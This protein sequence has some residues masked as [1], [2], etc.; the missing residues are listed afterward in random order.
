MHMYVDVHIPFGFF[1]LTVF[2]IKSAASTCNADVLNIIFKLSLPPR[3]L[4]DSSLGGGPDS[5]WCLALRTKHAISSVCRAWR[6]VG[7]ELLYH[8]VSFRRIH[9]AYIFLD[10]LKDNPGNLGRFVRRMEVLCYIPSEEGDGPFRNVLG[11]ILERCPR[12]VAVRYAPVVEQPSMQVQFQLPLLDD[13]LS[14]VERLDCVGANN[15]SLIVPQLS[16]FSDLGSLFIDLDS[17][18]P[19]MPALPESKLE[20]SKLHT[21]HLTFPA[22]ECP[23]FSTILEHWTLP[24]LEE[25]TMLGSN[26]PIYFHTLEAFCKRFGATLTFLHFGGKKPVRD[27]DEDN[28]APDGLLDHCPHLNHLVV[29]PGFLPDAMY[30]SGIEYCDLWSYV[31]ASPN[32]GRVGVPELPLRQVQMAFPNLEG[33]RV[34]DIALLPM[35]DLPSLIWPEDKTDFEFKFPG[36]HIRKS[37]IFLVSCDLLALNEI[38]TDDDSEYSS[39]DV[40]DDNPE[41]SPSSSDD[42]D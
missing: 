19:D 4:L 21:L 39:G 20:L 16:R 29:S 41:D 17:V 13:V 2:Q 9:Q 25:L 34:L 1:V 42:S 12:L 10:I 33:I 18:A 35:L 32:H 6:N 26:H 30:H 22:K 24:N 40:Q 14:R 23:L 3:Y 36:I 38:M 37:D 5:P 31:F 7:I 28:H 8:E 27:S 15:V 11:Q